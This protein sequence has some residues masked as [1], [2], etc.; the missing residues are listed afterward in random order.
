M[1]T[2]KT[3]AKWSSAAARAVVLGA[4]GFNKGAQR[5][6][7]ILGPRQEVTAFLKCP[8]CPM[9]H[10]FDIPAGKPLRRDR[11][12]SWMERRQ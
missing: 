10:L 11:R 6:L 3:R 4:V 12:V 2:A 8:S 9:I 7:G 5:F 1:W